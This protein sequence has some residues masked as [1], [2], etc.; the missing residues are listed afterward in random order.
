M[1]PVDYLSQHRLETEAAFNA[2]AQADPQWGLDGEKPETKRAGEAMGAAAEALVQHRTTSSLGILRKLEFVA[3]V[4]CLEKPENEGTHLGETIL[5][6]IR[7]L[8]LKL[9][10]AG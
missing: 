6:L 4:E 8:R 3:D 5:S 10:V 7:D 2:A 1:D 9:G